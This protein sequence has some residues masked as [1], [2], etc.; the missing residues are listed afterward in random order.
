MPLNLIKKCENLTSKK[1][2]PRSTKF[3]LFANF[4]LFYF[5]WF[6]GVF[7]VECAELNAVNNQKNLLFLQLENLFPIQLGRRW[8]C[9]RSFWKLSNSWSDCCQSLYL[10]PHR[11]QNSTNNN[12]SSK[13]NESFVWNG[14]TVFCIVSAM[15]C[16]TMSQVESTV[17]IGHLAS[18]YVAWLPLM[19]CF[20]FAF[21]MLLVVLQLGW[22]G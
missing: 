16:R 21:F 12:G 3:C 7:I 14:V 22:N 20:F 17:L 19:N 4:R 1:R 8:K 15:D 2:H 9:V 13:K 5:T 10:S 6:R 18:K 11:K